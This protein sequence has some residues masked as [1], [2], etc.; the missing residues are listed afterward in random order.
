MFCV[1][2][3]Y[4]FLAGELLGDNSN[5]NTD[6]LIIETSQSDDVTATNIV[7]GI[8]T[9]GLVSIFSSHC[10]IIIECIQSVFNTDL[11]KE[12]QIMLNQSLVFINIRIIL[13]Y[14]LDKPEMVRVS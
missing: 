12:W 2:L 10:G 6:N 5:K 3:I 11:P 14:V 13:Y 4:T 7:M 1:I 9:E 8:T